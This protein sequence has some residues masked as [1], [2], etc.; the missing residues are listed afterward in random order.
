MITE[1]KIELMQYHSTIVGRVSYRAPNGELVEST[2]Y[3]LS[4]IPNIIR[5]W[6]MGGLCGSF[7]INHKLAE[8]AEFEI[9]QIGNLK[10]KNTYAIKNK[11]G[12]VICHQV[13]TSEGEA[14]TIAKNY[15]GHI[16][17]VSAVMIN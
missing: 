14:L 1:Y 9:I 13:A 11:F 4:E 10:M 5:L 2:L 7:A 17:A 12:K 16:S 8:N 6:K 3:S 15:Y